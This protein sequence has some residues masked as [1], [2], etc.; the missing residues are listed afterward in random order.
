VYREIEGVKKHHQNC[1]L[2]NSCG[3]FRLIPTQHLLPFDRSVVLKAEAAECTN[4]TLKKMKNNMDKQGRERTNDNRV[5]IRLPD[6]K[7][8]AAFVC[9]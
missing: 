5:E 6:Q 4:A 7:R 2:A 9:F 8:A 1:S 3:G